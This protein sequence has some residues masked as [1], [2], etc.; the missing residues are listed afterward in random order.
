MNLLGLALLVKV[1]MFREGQSIASK[2]VFDCPVLVEEELHLRLLYI[3][4]VLARTLALLLASSAAFGCI[5]V[6]N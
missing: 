5:A 2:L 3:V 1:G 4:L 6:D